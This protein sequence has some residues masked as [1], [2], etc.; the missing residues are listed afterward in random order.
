M[1]KETTDTKK[2]YSLRELR[3][4]SGKTPTHSCPNCK[5]NRY[6]ECGCQRKAGK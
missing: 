4:V 3:K 1:S 5:C 2:S 6:S